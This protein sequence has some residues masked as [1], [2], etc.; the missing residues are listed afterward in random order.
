MPIIPAGTIV[1]FNIS[2]DPELDE[3]RVTQRIGKNVLEE[4]TYFTDDEEDAVYTAIAE[5]ER[6]R[7]FL[8]PF[9]TKGAIR[10]IQKFESNFNNQGQF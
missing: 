7:K 2:R 9:F 10:R 6:Q 1:V 5:A 8:E 3:F 4:R